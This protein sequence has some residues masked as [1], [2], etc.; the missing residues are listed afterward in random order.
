MYFSADF[1]L[2]GLAQSLVH[3]SLSTTRS[4]LLIVSPAKKW[5]SLRRPK[6]FHMK[7]KVDNQNLSF[8][9][10]CLKNVYFPFFAAHINHIRDVAGI[11]YVGEYY[12]DSDK[13]EK[14]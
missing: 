6:T 9:N 7:N 1:S 2:F 12:D 13:A 5:T 3:F 4:P 14:K 10:F 8:I 11:D